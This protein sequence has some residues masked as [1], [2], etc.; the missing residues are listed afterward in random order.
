MGGTGTRDAQ[1]LS[2]AKKSL[3]F[4]IGAKSPRPGLIPWHPAPPGAGQIS[5]YDKRHE[6]RSESYFQSAYWF[7][8]VL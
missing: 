4:T 2:R 3:Q 8:G 6:A 1:Q 5:H 7:S